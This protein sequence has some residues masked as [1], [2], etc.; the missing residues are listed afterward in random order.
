MIIKLQS[1]LKI[2]ASSLQQM[3]ETFTSNQASLIKISN[4]YSLKIICI[5]SE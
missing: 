5:F 4:Y 3:M 2:K 1:L